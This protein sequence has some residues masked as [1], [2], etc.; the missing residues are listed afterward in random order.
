VLEPRRV[1]DP[2]DPAIAGFGR[3]QA[4]TYFEPDMLIPPE[5]IGPMLQW[6]DARR[7]NLLIVLEDAGEV[8]AGTLFHYLARPN[9][10]FSSYLA[11]A[12]ERRGEG[13]ARRLHTARDA[14]LHEL[15][16]GAFNGVFI[17]VVNPERLSTAELEEE[18]VVGSDP[19]H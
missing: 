9:V 1:T 10:G 12:P 13:L 16:S 19:R 5:V 3:L 8:V 6:S 4:R 11:V 14:L 7:H 2:A 17:D 18:R 15:S